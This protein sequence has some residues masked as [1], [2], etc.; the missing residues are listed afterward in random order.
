M[1]TSSQA[2][3]LTKYEAASKG[4]GMTVSQVAADTWQ[5][6]VYFQV[7]GAPREGPGDPGAKGWQATLK[8]PPKRLRNLKRPSG[9]ESLL[10]A[11]FGSFDN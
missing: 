10:T 11:R 2:E 9:K 8:T 3:A 1:L 6:L 5:F 4:V 7:T